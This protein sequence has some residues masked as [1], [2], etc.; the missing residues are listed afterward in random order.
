MRLFFKELSF[1]KSTAMSIDAKA[2]AREVEKHVHPATLPIVLKLLKE[3]DYFP[4]KAKRPLK[5]MKMPI[6]TC[7]AIDFVRRRGWT[8]VLGDEDLT[9]PFNSEFWK[10]TYRADSP[11]KHGQPGQ[12]FQRNAE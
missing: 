6:P 2:F 12:T 8:L 10:A 1:S 4:L 9:C 7:G 5:D 3:T 11:S